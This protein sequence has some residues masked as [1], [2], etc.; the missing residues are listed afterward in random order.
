M[1]NTFT[2]SKEI[3]YA[4]VWEAMWGSEGS[5]S[6][7]ASKIRKPDGSDISLWDNEFKPMPQPFKVYDI[8]EEKWHQVTLEDIAEAYR[9]ADK[10]HLTHCGR[11]VVTN[12][13]DPDECT[14]D[15][16][17]QLAVFGELTYG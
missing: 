5:G 15:I 17:L 11:Y 2:V 16:L 7:W 1:N 14:G 13:D 9:I 12:F 10:E 3:S 6:Q 8:E 4:D